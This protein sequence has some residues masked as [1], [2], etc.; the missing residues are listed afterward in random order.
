M[1]NL[2]V[3]ALVGNV[4]R[5]AEVRYTQGGMAVSEV[6]LAVNGGTKDK[7]ETSFFDLQLW[8]KTAE[9][10]G[11]WLKKG[12]SISVQGRLKQDRWEKDGE[13]RSKVLVVVER[14]NFVGTKPKDDSPSPKDATVAE[15]PVPGQDT[16]F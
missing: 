5:D 10:A 9:T 16:P 2:N 13:R 6:G 4:T 11:E 14:F 1:S 3:V 7:P 15:E 12:K 8:G